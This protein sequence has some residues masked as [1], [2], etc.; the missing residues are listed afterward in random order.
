MG[1][2][3]IPQW[4]QQ[5]GEIVLLAFWLRWMHFSFWHIWWALDNDSFGLIEL[6]EKEGGLELHNEEVRSS[7]ASWRNPKLIILVSKGRKMSLS[8]FS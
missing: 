7:S 1:S 5:Q 8:H 3:L 2:H 6:I 4:I